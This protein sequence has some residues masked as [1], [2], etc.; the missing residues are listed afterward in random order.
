[1]EVLINAIWQSFFNITTIVIFLTPIIFI[2]VIILITYFAQ[3]N[4]YMKSGYYT[5]TLTSFSVVRRDKGLYGEYLISNKLSKLDGSKRFLYNCYIPK[6][7]NT[8]TEI[9]IILL[10]SSG[11]YVFESKNYSGWIYGS[12]SQKQWTQTFQNGKKERFYNPIMQNETHIKYL[13]RLLPEFENNIFYSIIVF[14]KRCELKKIELDTNRHSVVKRNN[15][16][17]SVLTTAK[18]QI[19]SDE[20]IEQTYQKLIQYTQ[21]SEHVKKAHIDAVSKQSRK[22]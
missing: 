2:A 1:M 4:T 22:G 10:H 12:E 5:E 16:L 14:S 6:S 13:M 7:K 19:L 11:I 15:L 9:D 3:R 20:V 17:R 21:V 18:L 8:T